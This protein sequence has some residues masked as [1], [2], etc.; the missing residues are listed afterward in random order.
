MVNCADGEKGVLKRTGEGLEREFDFGAN[1]SVCESSSFHTNII[2]S[3][4]LALTGGFSLTKV[5]ER[6]SLTDARFVASDDSHSGFSV[7]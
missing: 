4:I 6:G 7:W 5:D 2:A 3:G 1:E